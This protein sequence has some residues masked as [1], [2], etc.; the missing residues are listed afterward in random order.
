MANDIYLL[1]PLKGVEARGSTS[2]TRS[3]G[4]KAIDSRCR[5]LPFVTLIF[6]T[7]Y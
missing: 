7:K 5:L 4:E 6:A 2:E 1:L 3:K